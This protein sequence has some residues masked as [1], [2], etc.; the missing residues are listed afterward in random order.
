MASIIIAE[1]QSNVS[2]AGAAA[3]GVLSHAD[4]QLEMFGAGSVGA[5]QAETVARNLILMASR[6]RNEA[7]DVSRLSKIYAPSQVV[8]TPPRTIPAM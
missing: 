2:E 1:F 4:G 3:F 8:N 7:R 6:I 5:C